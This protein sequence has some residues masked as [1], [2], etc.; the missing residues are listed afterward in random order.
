MIYNRRT[1][2]EQF[3]YLL[4]GAAILPACN[5]TNPS[6]G[7][8]EPPFMISLAQWSLQYELEA[9]IFTNKSFPKVAKEQ[10][11]IDAVE[12]VNRFFMDKARDKAY[13]GELKTIT[14]DLGVRNLLIMVDGEGA[15]GDQDEKRRK[16]AVE[17]HYQW[18]EASQFLG[19]HSIRV[20]AA[21]EGSAAEVQ[22]AVVESLNELCAFAED[23]AIN[24]IV[25]NHGGYSS[26]AGWLVEVMRRVDRPNCGALPDFG[27]FVIDRETGREYDRYQGVRELMPFAKAVSAKCYAFNEAGEETTIDFQRMMNIVLDAGYSGYV[28]IEYE[29]EKGTS[30]EGIRSAKTLLEKIRKGLMVG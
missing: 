13:L 14:D 9:G 25:E 5:S 7:G 29:G 1:F 22:S 10:F 19:G 4:A 28:G 26:D 2:L 3:G 12:Y 24:V 21:G 20:N 17:N 16:R 11:G 30:T 27:N 8:S 6:S 23:Y 15:L 18:V